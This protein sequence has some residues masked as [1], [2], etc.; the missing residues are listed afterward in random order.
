M[1]T[2]WNL[3][4]IAFGIALGVYCY[5]LGY[6]RGRRDIIINTIRNFYPTPDSD[7]A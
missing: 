3:L 2:F 7:D 6:A 4:S 5:I 1:D